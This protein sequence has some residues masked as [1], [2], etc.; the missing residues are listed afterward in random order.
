M[1]PLDK[2][3]TLRRQLENK[4]ATA[5]SKLFSAAAD[6]PDAAVRAAMAER[7]AYMEALDS[8]NKKEDNDT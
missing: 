4:A 8:L 6:S 3:R 7:L 2:L 1:D 5:T